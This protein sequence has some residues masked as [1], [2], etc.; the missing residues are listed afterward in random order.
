MTLSD[1]SFSSAHELTNMFVTGRLQIEETGFHPKYNLP[2]RHVEQDIKDGEVENESKPLED[3]LSQKITDAYMQGYVL[4]QQAAIVQYDE[5]QANQDTL[6]AAIDRLGTIDD[7]RLSKQLSEAVLSLFQ[8]AVGNAKID[9]KMLQER[10]D[11]AL[12]IIGADMDE[13]CLHVA[14]CDAK[15]LQDYDCP[16]AV[17]ADADLLPGSV[18]VAYKSGQIIGGSLSMA[19]EIESHAALAGGAT[20]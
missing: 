6:A 15:I 17:V 9:K 11:A 19:Q 16:I 1:S 13:A 2:L 4:G 8:Q 10:C 5:R 20:C 14:P 7:G 3:H 12:E 18:R